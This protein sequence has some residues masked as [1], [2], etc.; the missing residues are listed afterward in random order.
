MQLKQEQELQQILM[1]LF[2]EH[3][4]ILE[5]WNIPLVLRMPGLMNLWA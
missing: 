2:E 5:Q 3:H 4:P 1:Q